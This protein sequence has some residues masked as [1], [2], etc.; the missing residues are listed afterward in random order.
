MGT[1]RKVVIIGGVAAGP[2][3]AARLRRLDP[4][5]EITIVEK[6]SFISYAGCSLPYYVAGVV[7]E[8][9]ELIATPAGAIR[10]PAF[11]QKLLNIRVLTQTEA[12]RID[13]AAKRVEVRDAAGTRWLNYDVLVLATGAKPV[14]PRLP[15]MGLP[16]VFTMHRIEDAEG[17]KACLCS[18]VAATKEGQSDYIQH[19]PSQREVVVIG[20]GLIGVEMA[21]ALTHI[22]CRVTVVEMLPQ[23]LPMLDSELALLV[24]RHMEAKGV[25]VLTG[26]TATAIQGTDR[27]EAVV[28][29]G[30]RLPA[31]AVV[32][33]VGVRPNSDLARDAGLEL[34]PTGGIKVDP[35]MRTSD[36]AIY[37]VG[38]CTEDRHLVTGQPVFIS[39]GANANKKGRVAAN[40]IAG[41]PD[42]FP[43]IVGSTV[44]KVF[45]FAVARTGLTERQTREAGY[46]AETCIVPAPDK[47]HHYPGAKTIVLKFVADRRSR[48]LL[49]AQGVGPGDVA[50]RIDVAATALIAGMTVDQIA[51]LDLCYAPPFSAAMDNVLVAANVMR[52][53]LDG[54]MHGISAVEVRAKQEAGED[55]FFLDVRTPAEFEK[56]SIPGS[57]LVPLGALGSKLQELPRDKEIIAFCQISLRGYSAERL[58]RANGFTRVRVMEGGVAAWPYEKVTKQA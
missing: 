14:L 34:G 13:R 11:F 16:N 28:V 3:T 25:R 40:A 30:E 18:S 7:K 47:V 36:P 22:G 32:V 50:R 58:L 48:K 35:T 1:G 55:F 10:D 38:D 12:L 24:Q 4:T 17:I 21:E 46:D 57:T 23:I 2:K 52:N 27:A 39:N 19:S 42:Q 49:G 8:Q 53:K 56:A 26:A 44:C 41:R 5:A 31:A 43:G 15:G 29:G 37:A 9:K 54:L 45:D 51:N 20:G 33:A 6:G